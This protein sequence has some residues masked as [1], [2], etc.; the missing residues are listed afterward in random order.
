MSR[1]WLIFAIGTA[2]FFISQFYRASNAV[3]APQLLQDLALDTEEL[4]LVSAAFFYAFAATQIPITLLLDRVGARRL[5]TL[6]SLFGVG[7]AVVFSEAH[8]LGSGLAG[9]A[10]LGMGMACNLMGTLKLLTVW[11]RPGLFATLSGIV[12]AIGTVGN[13]AATTPFVL[14]VAETGWRAAFQ[15]IAGFNLLLI[16]LLWWVVRDAP[17]RTP[18]GHFSGEPQIPP[19]KLGA[20]LRRLLGRRDYWIISFCSLVS[21]GIFAAFQ[22]LWA[23]PFLI[24][25]MGLPAVTAGNLIFLMNLGMIVGGPLWGSLSDRVLGT[26]KWVICGGHA[27]LAG[28]VLVLALLKPAGGLFLL[29]GL[30]FG[31]GLFRST[32]LLMYAQIKELM[33]LSMAG[34]AITG[35]NVFNMVGPAVFLQGLGALMQ[36]VYPQAPRGPE[37]YAMT[38]WLCLGFLVAVTGLYTLTREK[39]AAPF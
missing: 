25:T 14:L 35:V 11:F 36:A 38:F 1:A 24:E 32:G 33:P 31:F 8:S 10:L 6:L 28:V 39:K 2:N 37:A 9:R 16:A 19:G 12:F 17:P 4:G 29:G 7:G 15:W 34:T 18:G 30:L 20:D 22:T 23:G 26:R 21:Y 27:A 5:M 3:I 13:M